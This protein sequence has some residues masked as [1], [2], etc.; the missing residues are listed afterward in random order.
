MSYIGRRI[1]GIMTHVGVTKYNI[2]E[3][4][5]LY[6]YFGLPTMSPIFK[7]GR[8]V[9]IPIIDDAILCECIYGKDDEDFCEDPSE[10][11]RDQER[12]EKRQEL[13]EKR[14]EL[15][16]SVEKEWGKIIH[17][18]KDIPIKVPGYS[19][20]D[21]APKTDYLDK[22]PVHDDP[23]FTTYTYGPN[24][25]QHRFF[26][27]LHEGDKVFF[28]TTLYLYDDVQKFDE[29]VYWWYIVGYFHVKRV[30]F[31]GVKN[32]IPSHLQKIPKRVL[33]RMRVDPTY[34]IMHEYKNNAHIRWVIAK[35]IVENQ[36][37]TILHQKRFDKLLI[38]GDEPIWIMIVQGSEKSRLLDYAVPLTP[39]V[40]E[41]AGV[42]GNRPGSNGSGQPIRDL[43]E[44][45]KIE[46]PKKDFQV[47]RKI[48]EKRNVHEL[49][50]FENGEDPSEKL[51]EVIDY[52]QRN[53]EVVTDFIEKLSELSKS[54]MPRNKKS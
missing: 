42:L 48:R 5:P 44:L 16:R 51:L 9:L 12:A 18:Y 23:E 14:L 38:D 8:F 25:N 32:A 39:R 10:A 45:F 36:W 50:R 19:I 46:N 43:S 15:I 53:P 11:S 22:I 20:E 29:N 37:N 1:S 49:Y 47:V 7:D 24:Y 26:Y 2:W 33:E 30:E 17:T 27:K 52:V 6:K 41:Y 3:I 28:V 34:D 40:Y 54:K 35:A 21:F 4:E 13:A 31:I